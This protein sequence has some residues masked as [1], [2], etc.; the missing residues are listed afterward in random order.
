MGQGQRRSKLGWREEE[1][2]KSDPRQSTSLGGYQEEAAKRTGHSVVGL[3]A[4]AGWE[5]HGMQIEGRSL[6]SFQNA[7]GKGNASVASRVSEPDGSVR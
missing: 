2:H 4:E 6:H 1:R 5:L 3:G 7:C